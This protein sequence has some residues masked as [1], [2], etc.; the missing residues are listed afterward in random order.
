[1]QSHFGMMLLFSA[2]VSLAFAVLLRDT[3]QEQV[4]LGA[5]LFAGF[6]GSGFLLGWLM[7]GFP[8]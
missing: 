3:A 1:V 5:M 4:R 2:F 7:Y 8:L 6:V